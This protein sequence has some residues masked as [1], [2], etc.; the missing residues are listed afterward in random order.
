[1]A[2]GRRR[3][4]TARPSNPAYGWLTMHP[5]GA[6][7]TFTRAGAD[8]RAI[9]GRQRQRSSWSSKSQKGPA[10]VGPPGS[11]GGNAQRGPRTVTRQAMVAQCSPSPTGRGPGSASPNSMRRKPPHPNTEGIADDGGDENDEHRCPA[12]KV[13]K[14]HRMN[15]VAALAAARTEKKRE[16][17]P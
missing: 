1:M 5:S 9:L 11:L 17:K 6:Y 4:N 8:R 10:A 2:A 7:L 16:R 3:R 15:T 12:A 13:V 14:N